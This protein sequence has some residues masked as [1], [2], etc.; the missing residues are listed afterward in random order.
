MREALNSNHGHYSATLVVRRPPRF[1]RYE[2][3]SDGYRSDGERCNPGA[4][5]GISQPARYPSDDSTLSSWGGPQLC[6]ALR[7]DSA[8][9]SRRGST[10]HPSTQR[11]SRAARRTT[12]SSKCSIGHWAASRTGPVQSATPCGSCNESVTDLCRDGCSGFMRRLPP[13]QILSP[14]QP[15]PQVRRH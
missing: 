7:L 13:T 2:P 3:R 9:R 12:G 4:H 5:P 11:P 8:G 6:E 10:C 14:R 15:T 1:R